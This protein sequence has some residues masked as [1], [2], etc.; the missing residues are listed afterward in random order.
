MFSAIGHLAQGVW[1]ATGGGLVHKVAVI[2]LFLAATYAGSHAAVTAQPISTNDVSQAAGIIAQMQ[3]QDMLPPSLTPEEVAQAEAQL[4]VANNNG[5]PRGNGQTPSQAPPTVT[6]TLPPALPNPGQGDLHVVTVDLTRGIGVSVASTPTA[7]TFYFHDLTVNVTQN[8]ASYNMDV[9][10]TL[11]QSA[12]TQGIGYNTTTCTGSRTSAS[13]YWELQWPTDTPQYSGVFTYPGNPAVL[14]TLQ[15]D[16]FIQ[17][18][19]VDLAG[20]PPA[21]WPTNIF[22]TQPTLSQ[23]LAVA[24]ESVPQAGLAHMLVPG[25]LYVN[26]ELVSKP[27]ETRWR[28]SEWNYAFSPSGSLINMVIKCA[29]QKPVTTPPSSSTTQKAP[30][31]SCVGSGCDF[32]SNPPSAT[33]PACTSGC[34]NPNNPNLPSECSS[35]WGIEHDPACPPTITG[36]GCH[37]GGTANAANGGYCVLWQ[38]VPNPKGNWPKANYSGLPSSGKGLPTCNPPL[39]DPPCDV[40]GPGTGPTWDGGGAS[41]GNSP[42]G[43]SGSSCTVAAVC[44]TIKQEEQQSKWWH[45][46]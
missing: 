1:H 5:N 38:L 15:Q 29:T 24:G 36:A 40:Y 41:S 37:N 23:V 34:G 39:V 16:G 11:T 44:Q 43:F 25:T 4:G 7:E 21:S 32:L 42:N 31:T 9:A 3:Q 18:S 28:V 13:N 46:W 2:L 30:W 27:G 8:S 33:P 14:T 20:A 10:F 45:I 17:A 26:L 22:T 19:K 35:L 6:V 12:K